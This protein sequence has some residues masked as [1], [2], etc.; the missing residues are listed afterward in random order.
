MKSGKMSLVIRDAAVGMITLQWMLFFAP[1][2]ARVLES[3]IR[4]ILAALKWINI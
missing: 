2:I 1:S 4:P 3:P